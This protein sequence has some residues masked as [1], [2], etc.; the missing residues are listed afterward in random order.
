METARGVEYVSDQCRIDAGIC[1][2]A[3]ADVTKSIVQATSNRGF[4]ILVCAQA[5]EIDDR[6]TRERYGVQDCHECESNQ[7]ERSLTPFIT[8]LKSASGRDEGS[9]QA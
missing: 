5:A 3:E 2:I 8:P 7:G 4:G 6:E 9:G 1:D